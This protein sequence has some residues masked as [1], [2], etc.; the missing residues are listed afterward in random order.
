MN[1]FSCFG[2]HIITRCVISIMYVLVTMVMIFS[3]RTVYSIGGFVV[4][5][6]IWWVLKEKKNTC[7]GQMSK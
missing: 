2:Q 6:Y 1:V 7:M 3:C 5:M 4:E